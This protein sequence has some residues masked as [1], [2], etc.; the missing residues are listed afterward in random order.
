[1]RRGTIRV[2]PT[3]AIFSG[4][5]LV[6]HHD[7]NTTPPAACGVR[8]GPRTVEDQGGHPRPRSPWLSVSAKRSG[9]RGTWDVRRGFPRC[10]VLAIP[11]QPR[12][13]K[14]HSGLG[15]TV[16]EHARTHRRR[17][18]PTSP[19]R[20]Q[21]LDDVEGDHLGTDRHLSPARRGTTLVSRPGMHRERCPVRPNLSAYVSGRR[22]RRRRTCRPARGRG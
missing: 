22:G 13:R 16:A 10:D 20:H 17:R 19:V 6:S 1:M 15:G 3:W 7:A 12:L 4:T 11:I 9:R 8:L 21:G 18:V 2:V 5:T 14:V